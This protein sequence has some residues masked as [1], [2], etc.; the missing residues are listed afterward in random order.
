MKNEIK[1]IDDKKI[2]ILNTP[3]DYID[4]ELPEEIDFSELTEIE[5]PVDSKKKVTVTLEPEIAKHFKSSKHLN[6][7]LHLQLKSLEKIKV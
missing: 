2:K 5:N 3:C 1:Y 7:F 6:Q 4:D